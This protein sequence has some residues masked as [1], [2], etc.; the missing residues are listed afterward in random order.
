MR[1]LEDLAGKV[2]ED[3]VVA[4]AVGVELDAEG[5]QVAHVV[6]RG[7]LGR[8]CGVMRGAEARMGSEQDGD[9]ILVGVYV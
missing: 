6:P 5:H 9:G 1:E 4:H 7:V 3:D 8:L 2:V